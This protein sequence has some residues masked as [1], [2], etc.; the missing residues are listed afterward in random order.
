MLG[1]IGGK[2]AQVALVMP[3][4]GRGSRFS[5]EGIHT[6]KPLM[7]LWGRPFFWWATESARRAFDIAEMVFVVLREHVED[8]AID[9][10]ILDHYPAARIAV[11]D[12][13]TAGAAAT[14]RIGVEAL[15]GNGPL[16]L[17][18]SDHAFVA[19]RGDAVAADLRNGTAAALLTF[20]SS[21]PAFSYASID[22]AGEVVGTVEKQVVSGDAIA[23]AYL[24][25][26]CDRFLEA[27]ER[28][29]AACPYDEIYV[30]GLYN[31]LN[32]AHIARQRL[33][34]HISFGTPAELARLEA[35]GGAQPWTSWL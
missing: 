11:C 18:D 24:F 28:Y 2:L 19:R 8:F 32:G 4:A 16:L 13:V 3:M 20:E 21:D 12:E 26:S 15:D 17:N 5:R 30:S 10:H 33:Q 22:P 6:P 27:Y 31:H 14:A 35:D 25:A 23:G 1:G 9:R 29:E 34:D 7:D